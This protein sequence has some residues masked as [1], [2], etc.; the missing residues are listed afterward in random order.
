V[1]AG[2]TVV[3]RAGTYGAGFV[4]GWDS[5]PAGTA[6][7]PI[8]FAANPGVVI[9]GRNARTADGID[10]EP[11]TDYVVLRGFTVNNAS[12]SITRAG[13]RVVGSDHVTV[14]GNTCDR[15]G[16][17]GIFTGFA[18]DLTIEDNVTSRSQSQHGIYVSNSG[19]RPVIRG[20]VSFG[21]NGCGIHMNG[22]ASQGGDGVISGALVERNVI[23]DNGAGGGSGINC[24]GVQGSRF[25][26]NLLYDNHAGGI[27]LFRQDGGGGSSGNVVVNNTVVMA[28]D[29]R[30]AVNVQD[31]STGNVVFNNVLW[32]DQSYRGAIDVSA[33][34]RPGFISDY[35]AVINKFTTDDSSV[36]TLAQWQAQTGQ[37]RHSVAIAGPAA[38]FVD[39]GGHNYRLRGGSAAVDL[40]VASLGGAG[41]PGYDLAGAV[42]PR[43]AG[44]D[45]GAYEQLAGDANWDGRIN[46]DDYALIDRGF[47]RH[48]TGWS[49]GDFNGDGK[50]DSKDY[51]I[52]DTQDI[53][54]SGGTAVPAVMAAE[55]ADEFGKRYV[56]KLKAAVAK[57]LKQ[58]GKKGHHVAG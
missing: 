30:W 9:T 17:W 12:G 57:A 41:A 14:R 52:I 32:N 6:A 37:D 8:T 7:A 31:G 26:D 50:V 40:G 36:I 28:A 27:T 29:G 35:N 45:A 51:L 38:V 43:G 58:P 49:N 20:N 34:S 19:D 16:T 33:D 22:D 54:M 46:A 23:Y 55:R 44:F 21:N 53:A 39:P 25:Q 18:D 11:G 15:N 24:D 13:I 5:N 47:A 2:D 56:K 42:R 48:L 4:M 10:L 3:V 1:R